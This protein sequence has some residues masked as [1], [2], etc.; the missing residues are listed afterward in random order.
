MK[1]I[2][3]LCRR[4]ART[5]Y[6]RQ[7][8]MIAGLGKARSDTAYVGANYEDLL[9]AFDGTQLAITDVVSGTDVAEYDGIFLFGWF[10][11]KPISDVARAVAHYA[12]AHG[13]PFV[14]SEVYY[15]RSF[16]KLSQCVIAVLNDITVTPFLFALDQQVLTDAVEARKFPVP[17]IAKAVMASRGRDN[18]LV[19]SHAQLAAIIAE[20]SEDPRYF[21]V[22][23]FIP[24][25]GDYRIV[26]MG[27]KVRFV[28]HR[29][30]QEGSHLNNTSQGGLATQIEVSELP[31]EVLASAIELA[32]LFRREVSGID[33][34][35][36]RETGQF[37][38]LETNNMPQLA[39]G[40]F[41]P[42][43]MQYLSDYLNELI[44]G[45]GTQYID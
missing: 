20:Q 2:L 27:G 11:D 18:Y 8:N 14:N 7:E 17:Y 21:I 9:F 25:D 13:I 35:Q 19:T 45:D 41:V 31:E 36:H 24:N 40:S 26:A 15:G 12:R 39:T 23:E 32:R 1:K 34:I 30:A 28:I 33:M 10:K 5:E 42:Q 3:V 22:Q 43:K 16:T 38:F 6:D 44:E 29:Q 4:E 37:Y